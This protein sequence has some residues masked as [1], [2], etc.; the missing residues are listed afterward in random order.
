MFVPDSSSDNPY[1][2]MHMPVTKGTKLPS[3]PS[4][5]HH[6]CNLTGPIP[7]PAVI[8]LVVVDADEISARDADATEPVV[9]RL[10]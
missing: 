3:L 1:M 6:R 10:T 4:L 8:A 2:T 5:L 9:W 7:V